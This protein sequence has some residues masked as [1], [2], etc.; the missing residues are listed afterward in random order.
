MTNLDQPIECAVSGQCG[1]WSAGVAT[2]VLP[3]P[4][5]H[6]SCPGRGREE[7][8]VL[9][10]GDFLPTRDYTGR[11]PAVGAAVAPGSVTRL[12]SGR[13]VGGIS[14][15]SRSIE[16]VRFEDAQGASSFHSRV[17]LQYKSLSLG[18]DSPGSLQHIGHRVC[19]LLGLLLD[20]E[21]PQQPNHHT[22]MHDSIVGLFCLYSRSLL[23]L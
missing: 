5:A 20:S 4:Y 9:C 23:P 11:I 18:L 21:D 17:V 19:D 22:Y 1:D 3:R 10:T 13:A 6:R 7:R 15:L 8:S 12:S 2:N 16:A 14:K